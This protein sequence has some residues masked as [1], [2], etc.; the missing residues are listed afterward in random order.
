MIN[1]KNNVNKGKLWN[2]GWVLALK[3]NW[4][5]KCENKGGERDI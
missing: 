2:I 5:H 3:L 1:K 4:L